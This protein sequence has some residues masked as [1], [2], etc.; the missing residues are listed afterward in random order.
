MIDALVGSEEQRQVVVAVVGNSQ[1]VV[2]SDEIVGH[3]SVVLFVNGRLSDVQIL[4][5]IEL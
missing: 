2:A 5:W 4:D 3:P 1:I